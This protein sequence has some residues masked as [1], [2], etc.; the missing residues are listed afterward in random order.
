MKRGLLREDFFYRI[1]VIP[2]TSPPLRERKE[3][4]P[5]LVEHFLGL[6]GDRSNPSTLPG[7]V[8]DSLYHYDWPGNVRELQNVLHRYLAVRRLDFVD[9]RAAHAFPI[10]RVADEDFSRGNGKLRAA[11]EAFEKRHITYILD[12]NHWNRGRTALTLGLSRKT[13]FRRMKRLGLG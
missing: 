10:D 9:S 11:M 4:I 8:L 6:Y 1:H 12:Q 7:R 5:L 3:D 2:I 13:L